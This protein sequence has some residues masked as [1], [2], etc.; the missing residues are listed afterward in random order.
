[1]DVDA[2]HYDYIVVGSGS[3]GGVLAARLSESGRFAV[4]CLEAGEKGPGYIWSRPPAGVTFLVDNPLVNWCY[5]AEPHESTGG[6]AIHVPRGKMLGGTSSING[7]VYN[8]G[9]AL[10]YDTWAQ[11]GC[12]GWSHD[13]V[14]PFFKRIERTELGLDAYRGRSGPVRVTEASKLSPFYDLFIRSAVAAGIPYNPDYSGATQ[15]GVAMAQQTVFRG[16]RQSTA[17]QFLAP[18][19]HR[20]NLTIVRGAEAESLLL[21]GSRC[22]GLRFRQRGRLC[23]ARAGREVVLCCGT[24]NSP[25]LL[26][27]SGIGDPAVLLE[28]GIEVRHALPGVGRNLRDHYAAMMRWAF[29]R[30]G[31][32]LAT[33]GNGLGLVREVLRFAVLRRG[34]IAQGIGSLRVFARSRPGLE[35]PDIM[36]VVAP[37]MIE[38]REGK[39]RRMSPV[40]GFHM[41]THVQRTESTG[42][43]HI[44]SRDP[45]APPRIAMR[46]LQTPNDRQT[47][48]LAVRR[49]REIVAQPPL[50]EVVASEL[51]PGPQVDSDSEIL[52]FIRSTGTITHHMVGTCRMGHDSLAVVDDRLRV[53]G[54]AGLRVADASI[55]PTIPSGN[56]SIPCMMV[57]EK[58]ADMLLADA[59]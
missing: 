31:I 23:E 51:Q 13:D 21:D 10:D 29:N 45:A 36:M 26:E 27:L 7:T 40:D 6:R 32:S 20:P 11:M 39:S 9:Q 37:Y 50:A 3:A 44:R 38:T 53:H 47:A 1:M 55:M 2:R 8:R 49:A 41:Y 52:D 46:F 30:P 25:K 5:T 17:T 56:T 59:G 35:N 42:S 48:I 12:R 57:G 15:E 28:H 24:A 58:C 14:L 34:F 16:L 43:I 54:L 4:L 19:Q 22:I 33:Q 18:A